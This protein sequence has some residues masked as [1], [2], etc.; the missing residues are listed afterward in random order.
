MGG[1]TPSGSALPV[2]YVLGTPFT[3]STL[4][5]FLLNAHPQIVAVGEATGPAAHE[6]DGASVICSCGARVGDCDFW[7]KVGEQMRQRGCRFDASRWETAFEL[8][9]PQLL[10]QLL[11][12]SLRSNAL[13][14]ARDAIVLRLPVWGPRLRELGVRNRCFAESVLAV[15]GKP[16]LADA[17]KDPLRSRYLRSL[18]GLDTRVIHLVRDAPGFVASYLK[19]AGGSLGQGV[20]GWVRISRAAERLR[21]TLPADAWLRVR[22]EDLCS[23][24]DAEL[25][26]IWRLAGVA[27]LRGAISW[28]DSVHHI[29]GNRMRLSN[30][31][32]IALDESWR[33]KLTRAQLDRILTRTGP[34]RRQYGYPGTP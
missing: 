30:S 7:S 9:V 14:A 22:Y 28:R 26:R 1:V 18:A 33:S 27:P 25:G 29:L 5:S 15:S 23:D 34:L 8:P 20:R 12:R 19:N 24:P 13:D 3:G 16:L 2:L 17:S 32:E 6:R 21:R 10:R 31:S 11:V 4:L